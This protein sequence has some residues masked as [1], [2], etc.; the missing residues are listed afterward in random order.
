M[1]QIAVRANKMHRRTMGGYEKRKEP[2]IHGSMK[3]YLVLAFVGTE[4][5]G[6]SSVTTGWR[7][8]QMGQ[9]GML[10][11]STAWHCSRCCF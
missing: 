4:V 1:L 9:F 11:V 7:Q 6:C 10:A 2:A 3:R 8:P 5:V